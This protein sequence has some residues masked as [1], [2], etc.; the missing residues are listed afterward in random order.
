MGRG[1]GWT[2]LTRLRRH[3]HA[4][5][6]LAV[7]RIPHVDQIKLTDEGRR[8]IP[9][10]LEKFGDEDTGPESSSGPDAFSELGDIPRTP[11]VPLPAA[12][13]RFRT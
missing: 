6:L 5:E 2:T 7:T 10:M 9:N 8:F 12:W 11:G 13:L 4:L 1:V 3:L